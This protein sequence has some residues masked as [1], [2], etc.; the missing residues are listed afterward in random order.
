MYN[1]QMNL[2]PTVLLSSFQKQAIH[3]RQGIQVHVISNQ[4][5]T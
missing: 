2:T 4:N 1:V 5:T 3:I